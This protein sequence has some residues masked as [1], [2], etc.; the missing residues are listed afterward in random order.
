MSVLNG[1]PEKISKKIG[2]PFAMLVFSTSIWVWFIPN[3]PVML[4]VFST[5][6]FPIASFM[7]LAWTKFKEEK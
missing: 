4:K 7:I 5:I 3:A 2:I 1:E 6:M